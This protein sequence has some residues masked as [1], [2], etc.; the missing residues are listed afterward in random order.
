[1]DQN[2]ISIN[3]MAKKLSVPTSWIYQRTRTGEMDATK[4]NYRGL[5]CTHVASQL[6]YP[7]ERGAG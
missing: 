3:E 7:I 4:L 2:L 1:M 5:S 6:K